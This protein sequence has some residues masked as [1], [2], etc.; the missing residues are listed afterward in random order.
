[1]NNLYL[2]QFCCMIVTTCL[3]LLIF[4]SRYYVKWVN[5]RY[6]KSRKLLGLSMICLAVHYYFQ[7]RFGL[8][9]M[10]ED[11]GI[12]A[13]IIFYTPTAYLVT[14]SII[15]LECSRCSTRRWLRGG[16]AGCIAVLS[17]AGIWYMFSKSIHFGKML[18]LLYILYI[19][20]MLL[21]ILTSYKEIRYRRRIIE[22]ETAGDLLPYTRY[23]YAGGLLLIPCGLLILFSILS[24]SLL[25]IFGTLALLMLFIFVL[26][27]VALGFNIVPSENYIDDIT[28][29]KCLDGD[30]E[31]LPE[32]DIND[33]QSDERMA[34]IEKT[35]ETWAASG[36]FKDPTVTLGTLSQQL[37]IM[38]SDLTYYFEKHIKLT[39]RVWLSDIRFHEVQRML[40]KYPEYNNDAISMECG[41]SSRAHLYRIFKQ[42]TGM[43][44]GEWK[45]SL[46]DKESDN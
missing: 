36:G 2:L 46:Q 35:L 13:N 31:N 24:S 12:L 15:N 17:T 30:T 29:Q 4:L 33:H 44:P 28:T 18:H 11:V 41:F 34:Q 38:R 32:Q 16:M 7:M 23:I 43:T 8:R 25:Q 45:L 37:H 1:M 19:I 10:G 20:S 42:K 3:A 26:S 5:K 39:F 40:K 9:A 14:S 6:E 22:T 27:F 21:F